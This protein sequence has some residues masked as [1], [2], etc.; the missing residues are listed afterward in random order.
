MVGKIA[1]AFFLALG[2]IQTAFAANGHVLVNGVQLHQPT[3]CIN[4]NAV[5]FAISQSPQVSI[6]NGSN[7]IIH[8]FEESNCDGNFKAVIPNQAYISH[9]E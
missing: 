8:F 1:T 3:G 6:E 2:F 4:V 5:Q 9:V 7:K